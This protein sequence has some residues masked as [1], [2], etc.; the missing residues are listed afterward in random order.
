MGLSSIG[1]GCMDRIDL[2]QG[3]D[4]FRDYVYKVTKPQIP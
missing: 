4:K 1:Y 2:G 3:R